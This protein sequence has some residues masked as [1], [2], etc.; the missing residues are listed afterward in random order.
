[1]RLIFINTKQLPN[2]LKT[3]TMKKVFL[4]FVAI[5]IAASSFAQATTWKSDPRHS[6]LKF[7]ITHLMVSTVSGAFTDFSATVVS[8]KPDFSDGVFTL[9]AKTASINTGD[10]QRNAHLKS[11][12]FFAADSLPTL[13]FVSTKLVKVSDGKYKVTGNLTIHGVTKVETLDLTYRGSTTSP[14]SKKPL[15]GFKVTG[16]IE[17]SDFGVGTKFPS[18]MLSDDVDITVEVEVSPI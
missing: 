5:A 4:S 14:M 6:Q 10:D 8:A 2:H 17:R 3:Q 12:D 11:A 13:N 1:L 16:T 9:T 7:D 18:A 15:A